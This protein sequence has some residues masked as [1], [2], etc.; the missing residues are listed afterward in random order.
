MKLKHSETVLLTRRLADL[1]KG[2]LP[3]SRSV[4]VLRKQ[5]GSPNLKKVLSSVKSELESGHSFSQALKLQN[6]TFPRI[7]IGI[8]QAGE[9]SGN[10]DASLSEL[11]KLLET[12]MEVRQRLRAA[13]VYPAFLLVLAM[14]VCAFLLGF[15][16]P[17]F[18]FLF[19]DLGQT[20]PLPTRILI[21]AS[22]GFRYVFVTLALAVIGGFFVMKRASVLARAQDALLKLPI[23]SDAWRN[24]VL[25]RWASMMESLL[26]SGYTVS[27]AIQLSRQS[28][29]DPF[30]SEALKKVISEIIQGKN[31][32]S[33]LECSRWF[34]PM[35]CELVGAAEETGQLEESFGRLAVSY[36]RETEHQWKMFLSFLE[37]AL[38]L[39]MGAVVGFV[40]LAM[41]LP[42]FEMSATLR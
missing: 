42:I 7:A 8:V 27:D 4:D 40:A 34:P 15:V 35:M 41:L 32:K 31:F 6:G 19:Q 37:P 39:G 28:I 30:F 13:L 17:R 10:L 14:V 36:R 18:Q 29:N 22:S 5:S 23:V 20:L 16:I 24:A 12:D 26:R 38:I 1:L 2:G 9:L 3:L 25:Q 11:A 33:A 21:L